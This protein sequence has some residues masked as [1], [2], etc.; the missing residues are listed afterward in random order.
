MRR[1]KP[2]TV[3]VLCLSAIAIATRGCNPPGEGEGQVSIVQTGGVEIVAG[4][5]KMTYSP[6]GVTATLSGVRI[7]PKEGCCLTDVCLKAFV[8]QDCD[9][10]ID[11]GERLAWSWCFDNL[12]H[13]GDG[14][15]TIASAS[16]SWGKHEPQP[17]IEYVVKICCNEE[18]CAQENPSTACLLETIRGIDRLPD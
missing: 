15:V 5:M 2:L 16:I 3:G 1:S 11:E 14:S 13:E 7:V 4:S 6:A 9:G 10:E 8:D 18:W 12:D 17:R